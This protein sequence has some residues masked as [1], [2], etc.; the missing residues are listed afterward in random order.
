MTP[1]GR[2]SAP[3]D[4]VISRQEVHRHQTRN[5]GVSK[6]VGLARARRTAMSFMAAVGA[7]ERPTSREANSAC[8][9]TAAAQASQFLLSVT[10][11]I[12]Y[13]QRLTYR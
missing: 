5:S 12:W 7:P 4:A 10:D 8:P 13:R 1:P 9:P 3:T 6:V 11:T 2:A